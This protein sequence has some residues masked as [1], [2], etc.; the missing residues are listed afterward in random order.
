MTMSASGSEQPPVSYRS[1]GAVVRIAVNRPERG[2]ALAGDVV[3]E[4]HSAVDTALLEAPAVIVL[5]GSGRD[6]STGLDLRDLEHQSDG[7]LLLRLIRIELLLQKI[8]HAPVMTLAL[9]RGRA[10]GAGADIVCACRA[11]VA[12]PQASF[13]M[14]GWRFGIALGTRRLIHRI[15]AANTH[16]MLSQARVLR[17]D[18]ALS[19]GLLTDVNDEADWPAV[20]DAA[21]ADARTLEQ[22][23]ST[24]LAAICT[25]DTRTAD[26]AALVTTAGR[27][28]LKQ[29]I[30]AYRRSEASAR[31][32]M[33]PREATAAATTGPELEAGRGIHDLGGLDGGPIDRNEHDY[34][35]WEKRVHAIRE[36]LPQKGL[37]RVDELRRV[38]EG[39]GEQTYKTLTYYEQ[40]VSAIVQVMIERHVF[41]IDEFGRKLAEVEARGADGH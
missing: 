41:S 2:N 7:D 14:P 28:G 33:K 18:Q 35:P 22:Q 21:V 32:S 40:W 9:C 36:L 16:D 27:P 15:G 25:P 38:I 29:R 24:D 31:A 6:F 11:R 37:L 30:E 34:A 26:L 17:A 20:V 8:F 23:A 39:Q 4:L 10:L 3:E 5:E 12:V 19:W 13:R 1:D